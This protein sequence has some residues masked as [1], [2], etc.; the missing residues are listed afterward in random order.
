MARDAGGDGVR[1]R[2]RI[3]PSESPGSGAVAES[4]MQN[5]MISPLAGWP[6]I[7]V[8]FLMGGPARS[9]DHPMFTAGF[10]G[11]HPSKTFIRNE[12]GGPFSAAL[13]ASGT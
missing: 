4:D 10:R 5:A 3:N 12:N 7:E 1:E 8:I 13:Q 2:Q 11:V 6:W 9:V